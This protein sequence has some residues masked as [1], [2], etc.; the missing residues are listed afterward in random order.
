MCAYFYAYR[1]GKLALL[2]TCYEPGSV[3]GEII[4]IT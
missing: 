1:D 4:Y 2:I 3:L